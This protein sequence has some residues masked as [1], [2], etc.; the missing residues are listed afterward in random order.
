MGLGTE[1]A[2]G[3]QPLARGRG[4]D[5]VAAQAVE[6]GVTERAESGDVFVLDGD[7]LGAELIDDRRQVR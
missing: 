4:C 7:A 5:G 1:I 2:Q 6:V 3:S